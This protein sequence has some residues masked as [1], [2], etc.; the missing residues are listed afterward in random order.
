[1]RIYIEIKRDADPHRCAEQPVQAHRDAVAFNMNMLALV[2]GKPQ[3]LSLK[4]VLQHY[5]T[6]AEVVRRRT[7]FDLERLALGRT[8]WKASRSPSTTSTR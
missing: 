5:S 7:E 4:A 8:S 3:T 6:T 2:D 1:M